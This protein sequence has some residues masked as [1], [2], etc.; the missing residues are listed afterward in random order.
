MRVVVQRV[1]FCEVTIDHVE[2]RRIEGGLLVLIGIGQEDGFEDIDWLVRKIV[3]MRI[4][5][6]QDDKMNLSVLDTG[7]E[8]M[9][10]SQFTLLASIKKGNRPSFIYSAKPEQAI[11]L[12]TQFLKAM[13]RALQKPVNSG[14]FGAQMNVHFENDGPITIFIDS[15]NRE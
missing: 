11:P 15:K 5:S 7:G 1:T 4:F 13:T 2:K 10:I 9:V 3:Q 12:Y 14:E 6:D 8:V